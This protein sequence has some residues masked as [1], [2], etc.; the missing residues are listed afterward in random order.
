MG[1]KQ[2]APTPCPFTP[3]QFGY[4]G[5]GGCLKGLHGLTSASQSVTIRTDYGGD[6]LQTRLRLLHD[7]HQQL[8]ALLPAVRATR[9]RLLALFTLGLIWAGT[10]S[11]P[12]I[13]L[14]LPLPA[15]APS[16]ERRLRRWLANSSV[17]VTALWRPLA[18][19]MLASRAGT[20]LTLTLD[21]TT[22]RDHGYLYVLGLVA[23]KRVL[24]LAWHL[25]PN[26]ARWR[27]GERVYLARL[28]RIVAGWLPPDCTVT[29]VADSG[30]T[31][32]TLIPLC[33]AHGWHFVLRVSADAKQGPV[34]PD[35]R[36]LWSLVPGEG[37]RWYGGARLFKRAGWF[38]LQVSICWRTGEQTPWILVSDL[39]AGHARIATYRR[40]ALAEATYQ[41]CKSRGWQLAATKLRDPNRLNRLLLIAF[42]ALWWMQQAGMRVIR[43]GERRRYDRADRREMSVQRLGRCAIEA[44]MEQ[45]RRFPLPFR[46]VRS[47]WCFTWFT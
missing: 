12:R 37:K 20:A 3:G 5:G 9:V 27:R 21:P 17:P 32:R 39:P 45:Q 8:Y 42:L 41:D 35:G 30:L 16:T 38:D 23:H 47:R 46:R 6:P 1:R 7:W 19:T 11:L 14:A 4:H 18:R 22:L 29:L 33:Q 10:V 34:L 44:R 43:Q 36:T 40:R 25:L 26:T 15:T 28:F 31:A 2:L 24:P 13:A